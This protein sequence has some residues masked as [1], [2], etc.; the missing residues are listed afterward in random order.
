MNAC[1]RSSDVLEFNASTIE[2]KDGRNLSD[3]APAPRFSDLWRSPEAAPILFSLICDAQSRVVRVWA[4]GCLR[5]LHPDWTPAP[6]DLLKLLNH[7][8]QE[9]QQFGATQLAT[10]KGLEKMPVSFWLRLLQVQ[11]PTILQTICDAFVKHVSGDRLDLAQCID[12]ATAR[13]APVARLGLEFLKQR[14]LKIPADRAA[15][16]K[17]AGAKCAAVGGDLTTWVLSILGTKE[18]YQVDQVIAFLDSLLPEIRLAAWDWLIADSAGYN[19]PVLWSRLTE[20]PFDDLRLKLVGH[21]ERRIKLPGTGASQLS[22]VW[23]SVLLGV[24]RG[25]RQ[26]LKAVH[27][28]GEAIQRAPEQ[29][30]SLLPVLAVAVRSVRLPEARAGLAA[31]VT[32]VEAQP[33]LAGKVKKYLPELELSPAEVGK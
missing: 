1:F 25:G 21:L 30:D 32:V 2:I 13:P 24:H 9:I 10:L 11:D 8:D 7:S 20:T 23:C 22:Q 31:V 5:A 16:T 6:D 18:N 27:Q 28:I 29:F 19:D 26:K 3:L 12:I 17:L 14:P 4:M 33:E 15:L